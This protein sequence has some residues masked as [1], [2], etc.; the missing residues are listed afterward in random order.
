MFCMDLI[1]M[2]GD[3]QIGATLAQGE[4]DIIIFLRDPLTPQ[5]HESDIS[6]S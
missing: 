6:A 5:P 4:L 3:Q 1:K 2:G